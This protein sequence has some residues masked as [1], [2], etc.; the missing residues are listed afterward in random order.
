[1]WWTEAYPTVAAQFPVNA[2]IANARA[3]G[4][5]L[6]PPYG[7]AGTR[8]DQAT[9]L[10]S[11]GLRPRRFFTA[12]ASGGATLAE[13]RAL[14]SFVAGADFARAFFAFAAAGF[15]TGF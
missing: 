10:V 1:M 15:F 6:C 13:A 7:S 3:G 5:G 8:R 9:A 14:R 12:G 11:A 4:G 2:S